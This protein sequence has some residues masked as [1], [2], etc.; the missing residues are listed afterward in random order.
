[1]KTNYSRK[2][3]D[4]SGPMRKKQ[5]KQNIS[6]NATRKKEIQFE[7]SE[8]KIKGDCQKQW[9]IDLYIIEEKN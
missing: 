9:E 7:R 4:K 3:L 8:R 5:R 1:M 2:G 6:Q